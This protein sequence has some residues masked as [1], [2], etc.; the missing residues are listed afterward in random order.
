M[1]QP[2]HSFCLICYSSLLDWLIL[3]LRS[4]STMTS[5]QSRDHECNRKTR[6]CASNIQVQKS[7]WWDET[8]ITFKNQCLLRKIDTDIKLPQKWISMLQ[9]KR[10]MLLRGVTCV[11]ILMWCVLVS[12]I[13]WYKSCYF[14]GHFTLNSNIQNRGSHYFILVFE[15]Q[16]RCGPCTPCFLFLCIEMLF[17]KNFIAVI[18]SLWR[19][20]A[21]PK[22]LNHRTSYSQISTLW[23]MI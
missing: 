4:R 23:W 20:T 13:E 7:S 10:S 1:V 16:L 8:S 14:L 18:I 22:F 5:D 9:Y 2:S 6:A 11:R 19:S 21:L 17:C 12:L 3:G 15:A